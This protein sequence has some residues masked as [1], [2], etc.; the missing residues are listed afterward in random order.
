MES[1]CSHFFN[2]IEVG[3][4]KPIW[5]KWNDVLK[6]KHRGG[7][8]V[9]SLYALNKG[10]MIK[11]YW[12][13][14]NQKTSLWTRVIKAIYG[15]DGRIN[16]MEVSGIRSCWKNIVMEVKNLRSQGIMV[17]DFMQRKIGNGESVSFWNDNWQG[18]GALKSIVPRL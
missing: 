4:K 1:I 12:K 15:E 7:L 5:V 2:G 14:F 8:G 6:D 18:G 17:D 10:L 11:W 16:S 3:S 9:A 13:F